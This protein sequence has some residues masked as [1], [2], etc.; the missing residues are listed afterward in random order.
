MNL[1]K[2][3]N[4]VL[5]SVLN[6]YALPQPAFRDTSAPWDSVRWTF[7]SSFVIDLEAPVGNLRQARVGITDPQPRDVL[8]G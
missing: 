7:D 3:P 1:V 8:R 2:G 5:S 6:E 4:S